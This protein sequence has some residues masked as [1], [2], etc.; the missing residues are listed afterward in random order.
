MKHINRKKVFIALLVVTGFWYTYKAGK[1][2]GNTTTV[3]EIKKI[4]VN[5]LGQGFCI[6]CR[7]RYNWD[8]LHRIVD[9]FNQPY[10]TEQGEFN[11]N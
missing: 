7:E 10:K 1:T 6:S 8:Q 4:P 2:A 9:E 11:A 3:V 5:I